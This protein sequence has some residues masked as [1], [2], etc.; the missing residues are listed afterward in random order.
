MFDRLLS[1]GS[2]AGIAAV[3]HRVVHG[4]GEFTAPV[5]IDPAVVERLE[6]F[7]KLAPL[8][9]EHN[10]AGIRAVTRREPGWPQIA[11]FDTAFHAS[12]P[13][14]QTTFAVPL[15]W[16]ERGMRRYGFHGV[17]YEWIASQLPAELGEQADGRVIV[18]HL[19]NGA[20]VCGMRER[21]S[22]RNS[23]GMTTVD[24]LVMGTRPGTLDAGAV[25][26][27][28]EAF[29]LDSAQVGHALHHE[30]G[31]LGLSGLSNDVRVL[32]ASEDPRAGFALE[33]F[34]ERAAQEIAIAAVALGGID[35]LV[36]T[37][38]IGENGPQIRAG[39]GQRLA[40]LGLQLDAA[41]NAA[42]E[43]RI[44]SSGAS[45]AVRVI[46]T[47]EEAVIAAAVHAALAH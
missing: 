43:R 17:S 25:L 7:T 37:A 23:M 3:G 33:R 35:A 31:L 21:R 38:G 46:P 30:S 26:H 20:S 47:D 18:A 34:C 27:A 8:H 2:I 1:S 29:G 28:I 39:I 14:L 19:G 16:R 40:W 22:V 13:A 45:I 24:G 9:Q 42:N 5:R 36:F 12:Q 10:L 11:C 32:L 4:G 6:G 15:A 41:R 44:E